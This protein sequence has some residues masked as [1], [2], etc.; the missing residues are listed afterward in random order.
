M[1]KDIKVGQNILTIAVKLTQATQLVAEAGKLYDEAM[2]TLANG[3]EGYLGQA[4]DN[5]ATLA[6][7]MVINVNKLAKYYNIAAEYTYFL[8]NEWT[9]FDE[10]LGYEIALSIQEFK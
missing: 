6:K 3:D 9:E 10:E 2:T 5:T 1:S 7:N 8:F 4:T